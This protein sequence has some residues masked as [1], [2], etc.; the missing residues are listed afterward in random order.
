MWNNV[1][2]Q[3]ILREGVVYFQPALGCCM[4]P[5]AGQNTFWGLFSTI[6]AHFKRM[7][8]DFSVEIKK[9]SF[10]MF[11]KN[12]GLRYSLNLVNMQNSGWLPEW[13]PWICLVNSTKTVQNVCLLKSFNM[14]EKQV[15]SIIVKTCEFRIPPFSNLSKVTIS[16]WQFDQYLW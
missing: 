13:E 8:G 7:F 14:N 9:K 15:L 12:S 1:T 16:L 2:Q 3:Y 11:E 10:K 6:F 5:E 4:Y